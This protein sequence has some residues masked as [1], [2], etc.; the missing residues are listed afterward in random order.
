M[1][2]FAKPLPYSTLHTPFPLTQIL[3]E[4]LNLRNI[5]LAR[6]YFDVY[7]FLLYR[8][9]ARNIDEKQCKDLLCSFN[10]QG[11]LISLMP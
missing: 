10:F 7:I 1:K 2:K 4:K 6:S 3:I 8:R 9:E 5:F 11:W